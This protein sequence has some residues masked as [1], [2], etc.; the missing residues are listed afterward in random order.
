VAVFA[1]DEQ[2]RDVDLDDLVTL[3][4]HVLAECDVPAEMELSLLLVDEEAMATMNAAH[5][6]GSGPTDVIAFPMDEP[7]E[8]PPTG[9]A[10]L[11]DVVLCPA[12]AATQAERAGHDVHS[13][14]RMLTVHGI[15]HLLGMDH[16]EPEDER[17]MFARTHE[18]LR[19]YPKAGA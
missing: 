3:S 13:E 15:L 19:S 6:H 1:A 5:L 18:L 4:G 9:P 7:G 16:A 10:V 8:S 17:A 12:V 14:L 2:D 11:G